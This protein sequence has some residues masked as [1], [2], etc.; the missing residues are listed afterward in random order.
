[1]LLAL[2]FFA[3]AMSIIGFAAWIL[4]N[5]SRPFQDET[6]WDERLLR[7]RPPQGFENLSAADL[8]LTEI[9][10]LEDFATDDLGS[11]ID[12]SA[13]NASLANDEFK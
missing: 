6:D 8:E 4:G 10:I 3:G 12:E 7:P 1:M 13:L 2:I 9:E 5:T 11:L